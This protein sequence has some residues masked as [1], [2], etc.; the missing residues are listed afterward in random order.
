[1]ERPARDV[2]A[3]CGVDQGTETVIY[4][5]DG[6]PVPERGVVN[7]IMCPVCEVSVR[8]SMTAQG[9]APLEG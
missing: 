7:D 3:W 5:P 6:V 8:A 1:M 2:C 9:I 4:W